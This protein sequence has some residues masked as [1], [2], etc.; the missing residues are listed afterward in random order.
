MNKIYYLDYFQK[1]AN[2]LD[3]KML[4]KNGIITEVGRYMDAIVLKLYKNTW[5]NHLQD[6]ANTESKIFFSI[7]INETVKKEK[8]LHYNLHGINLRKLNGYAI[9]SKKFAT[10]FRDHF[11]TIENDWPNVSMAF[12]PQTLMQGW[13]KIDPENFLPDILNLSGKFLNYHYLVD[14]TLQKFKRQ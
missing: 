10:A 12:G 1:A 6:M 11:S 7:W 3:Q 13:M 5:I 8:Q 4:K 2:R 9:E 14:D